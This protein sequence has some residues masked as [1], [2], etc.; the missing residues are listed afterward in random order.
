M[1]ASKGDQHIDLP[2]V[3]P[4]RTRLPPG[5]GNLV[6]VEHQAELRLRQ[7][8]VCPERGD[9]LRGRDR[10]GWPETGYSSSHRATCAPYLPVMD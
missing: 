8:E 6:R 10:R 9:P 5:D 3:G 7:A 4:E 2:L 1:G